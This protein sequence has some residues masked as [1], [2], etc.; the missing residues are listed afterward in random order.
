MTT[1]SHPTI[2]AAFVAA[3]AQTTHV[4][5]QKSGQ[6]QGATYKYA[7]LSDVI[8][9]VR[10]ILFAHGLAFQSINAPHP[11][12]A[13]VRTRLVHDSG[14]TMESEGTFIP[15]C[16]IIKRDG[17]VV[18]R[19]PQQYGIAYTYARRYDLLAMLGIAADDNDGATEMQ[20]HA[21]RV[22][23]ANVER[24]DERQCG[25]LV[26][27]GSAASPTTA[28]TK[29][30]ARYSEVTADD[31]DETLR[32]GLDQL[33]KLKRINAEQADAIRA[34][35]AAGTAAELVAAMIPATVTA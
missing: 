21:A 9:M 28:V 34:E 5:K 17:T 2:A 20:A 3:Q 14:E 33:V 18:P 29:L 30:Q 26:A 4:V 22:A 13:I 19:G 12:G 15:A 16:D 27:I 31:F 23:A 8:E 24:V 6:A 32:V 1:T 35:V 7:D 11:E 25:I 10:P